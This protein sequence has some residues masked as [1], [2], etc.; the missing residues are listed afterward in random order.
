M[1]I[2][3]QTVSSFRHNALYLLLSYVSV[4]L[5]IFVPDYLFRGL[6]K[7]S[8]ITYRSVI[9]RAMYTVLV[10]AMVHTPE[11]VY[12]VPVFN[13][14]SNLFI[15][16]WSW[17][18]VKKRFRVPFR[19]V[20]LGATVQ[21]LKDSAVFFAS[22]IAST[23][24]G[25]SNVFVLGLAGTTDAA[26]G[27]FTAANSLITNGRGMFSPISDSLY[28]YMVK[29]KNYKLVKLVLAITAPLI[30][31]GTA[32]LYIFADWFILMF[33]GEGYEG[34]VSVFRAMLPMFLITLPIYLL[35]FPTL[36]AMN[37]MKEANY[38]VMY[39][40][41]FHVVGLAVLYA[42]GNLTFLPVAWLTC[43]SET[44]VLVSRIVYVILGK[45]EQA[46]GENT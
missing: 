23:A 8:S 32:I 3:C 16:L 6:E 9:A 25:A 7:M 39:A 11:D 38:T 12:L 15:V 2:L 5:S 36:G 44:V 19:F 18:I 46:K 13:A 22:R 37:K 17:W 35:G 26:M 4:M 45:R 1:V 10:V 28:P 30:V 41:A 31:A 29:K 42:T 14:V 21:A 20:S 40:A 34:A 43:A 24:Y 27:Q 33:C